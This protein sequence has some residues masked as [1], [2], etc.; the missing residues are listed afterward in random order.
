M[1][2]ILT[3]AFIVL[4]IN[5]LTG[6]AQA[7]ARPTPLCDLQKN[8]QLGTHQPVRVSGVYVR[9]FEGSVLVDSCDN[10]EGTWVDF[11]LKSTHNEKKM[12][13]TLGRAGKAAVILVGELNG[14]PEPDAKLPPAIK[15]AYHP[16]W[17]HLG[18]FRTKLVVYE[19]VSVSAVSSGARK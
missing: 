19:I 4:V 11:E 14:P 16:G 9:G 5:S 6:N 7:Q 2:H 13:E 15:K 1:K 17:G 3:I 8:V 18:A 12:R 10:N